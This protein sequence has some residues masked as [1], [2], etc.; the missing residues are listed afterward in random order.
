M[1]EEVEDSPWEESS[2]KGGKGIDEGLE[3]S[4]DDDEAKG[5]PQEHGD[6]LVL[7]DPEGNTLT[8]RLILNWKISHKYLLHV[9]TQVSHILSPYPVA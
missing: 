8:G 2:V 9:I 1:E 4:N 7:L 5:G 6:D 3:D